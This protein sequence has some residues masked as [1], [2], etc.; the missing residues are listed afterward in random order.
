MRFAESSTSSCGPKVFALSAGAPADGAGDG[1]L[2]ACASA[3]VAS[4]PTVT[5]EAS[6]N[7]RVSARPEL[8]SDADLGRDI[9]EID[10][11]EVDIGEV[12]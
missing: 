9:G 10:I 12:R 6:A 8:A 5:S 2:G 1:A 3:G 7:A 4:A 11:G